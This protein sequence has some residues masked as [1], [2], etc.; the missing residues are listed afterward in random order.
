MWAVPDRRMQGHKT[1][2]GLANF[3]T[4]VAIPTA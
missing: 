2:N 3:D 1:A 4:L